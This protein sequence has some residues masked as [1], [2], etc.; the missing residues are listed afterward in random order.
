MVWSQRKTLEDYE[1]T[2]IVQL[3]SLLRAFGLI[4]DIPVKTYTYKDDGTMVKYYVV[5]M[6]PDGLAPSPVQPSREG[7]GQMVAYH[8]AV[9]WAIATIREYRAADLSGTSFVAIPHDSLMEEMA[10][11]H[12]TL[13]KK[14]PK[15]AARL[16][17]RY[18]KM[19]GSLYNTHQVLVEDKA[20]MLEDLTDTTRRQEIAQMTRQESEGSHFSPT[21]GT[22]RDPMQ[23]GPSSY[24]PTPEPIH[25][26]IITSSME[27]Q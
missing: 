10:L 21:I 26:P 22:R 5:I 14:K 12:T 20:E 4:T 1:G 13:V 25:Y 24:S 27:A 3:V 16:L 8:E 19:A 9:V 7:R 15:M 23:P 11:D 6:L 18:R 2:L 17:D